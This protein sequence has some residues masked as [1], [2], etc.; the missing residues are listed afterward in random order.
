[1]RSLPELPHAYPFRFVET[2]VEPRNEDFSRGSV[3]VA[4]SA[5]GRAASGEGW[6]SPL[7][8]AE[9]IA[10]SALLL[11]GA[12]PEIGR[13][14]YLA[15]IDGFEVS[16]APRAGETLEVRVRLAARFGAVVKFHGE[17]FCG[18]E[19]LAR[20]SVLV[21]QGGAAHGP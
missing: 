10:Q 4:V 12:D 9:A 1:V 17:V 16:R 2:V 15:G 14:G 7:L 19:S 13:T 18:A 3:R 11:E 6:Q 8:L 20:G 5:N 21:R